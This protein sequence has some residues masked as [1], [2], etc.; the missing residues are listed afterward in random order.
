MFYSSSTDLKLRAFSD[1]DWAACPDTRRAVSGFCMFLGDSLISWKSKKQHTVSKSSAEAEYRSMANATCEIVWL[2][3]LFKDL[4][5]NLAVPMTLFCD[6]QSAIHISSNP[7]FHDRTKHIEI[8]CHV[9]RER[10]Q[11]GLIKVSHVS[12]HL[13]LADTLTK[14]LLP[15]RFRDLLIKMGMQN[16]HSP[17]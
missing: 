6:N 1:S 11:R 14:S 13:Q 2:S 12:S 17:S 5:I 4:Q 15:S 10:I 16:I 8:D 3:S 9:V 7:V